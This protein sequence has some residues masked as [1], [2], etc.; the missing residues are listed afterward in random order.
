MLLPL[1]FFATAACERNAAPEAR[2]FGGRGRIG[3]RAIGRYFFD[4]AVV[5]A[6]AACAPESLSASQ[7]CEPSSRVAM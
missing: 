1:S 4:V 7:Y 5:V 3:C 6:V 2:C